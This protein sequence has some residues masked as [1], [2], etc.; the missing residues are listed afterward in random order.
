MEQTPLQSSQPQAPM[1]PLQTETRPS[2]TIDSQEYFNNARTLLLRECCRTVEEL[3]QIPPTPYLGTVIHINTRGE[4]NLVGFH[5]GMRRLYKHIF[6]QNKEVKQQ[7]VDYY[8][9]LGYGWCD[10]VPLNRTDWKIFLWSKA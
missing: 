9:A 1:P 8:R 7:I 2:F 10:I 6:L 5:P 3:Q 4:A